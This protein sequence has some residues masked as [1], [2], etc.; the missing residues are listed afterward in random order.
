MAFPYSFDQVIDAIASTRG[1]GAHYVLLGYL[2]V[3]RAEVGIQRF[4]RLLEVAPLRVRDANTVHWCIATLDP[5]YAAERL[6]RLRETRGHVSKEELLMNMVPL[7]PRRRNDALADELEAWQKRYIQTVSSMDSGGSEVPWVLLGILYTSDADG[8]RRVLA[9]LDD[10]LDEFGRGFARAAEAA[11]DD[12]RFEA[13]LLRWSK[14]G[15]IPSS[16][17]YEKGEAERRER[18][19]REA[20]KYMRRL[21]FHPHD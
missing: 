8:T 5:A 1:E 16:E 20:V 2:K 15:F 14:V 18:D 11:E 7:L 4:R 17:T 9:E 10:E 12:D 19:E 6:A 21:G 13:A 3:H